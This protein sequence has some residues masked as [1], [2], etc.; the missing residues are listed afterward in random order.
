MPLQHCKTITSLILGA[1]VFSASGQPMQVGENSLGLSGDLHLKWI[2]KGIAGKLIDAEIVLGETMIADSSKLGGS[3]Y[4]GLFRTKITQAL[5]SFYVHPGKILD[6]KLSMP[7]LIKQGPDGK[8]GP[9]GDLLVDVSRSWGTLNVVAAGL[10]L[11][12]PTGYSTIMSDNT[13]FLSPEN[14]VGSGL[15]GATV[16][17]SYGFAPDWGIINM[18]ASYSAGLFAIRTSE[19]GYDPNADNINYDTKAFQVA[20]D[21]WAARNDAGVVTPDHIGLFADFGIKSETVNHGISVG[22]YYPAAPMGYE[23][24]DKGNTASTFSTKA[25]AQEYLD[26]SNHVSNTTYFV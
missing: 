21:G 15:F 22:Y 3:Q 7:F 1:L 23:T 11:N 10:T 25:Q 26:T 14:Q 19:Y 6:L 5:V 2:G 12:F 16:R 20:R 13:T 8:T 4:D 24:L 18:G 9:F 17:A